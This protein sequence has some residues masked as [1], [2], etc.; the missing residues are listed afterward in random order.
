MWSKLIYNGIFYIHWLISMVLLEKHGSI[1]VSQS[2]N[3]QK[4]EKSFFLKHKM[5]L[6]A[7][8]RGN[9]SN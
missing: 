7:S 6:Y 4:K 2:K 9:K 5:K 1:Y 3:F 8:N